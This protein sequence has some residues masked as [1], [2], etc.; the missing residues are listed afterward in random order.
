MLRTENCEKL[1]S[2]Q[3]CQD[4][5]VRIPAHS[6]TARSRVT[7]QNANTSQAETVLSKLATVV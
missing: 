2:S 5:E 1:C 6:A 3:L 7:G 4:E